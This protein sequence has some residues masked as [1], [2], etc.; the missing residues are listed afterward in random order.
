MN[1]YGISSPGPLATRSTA[2]SVNA[3]GITLT[4]NRPQNDFCRIGI[5]AL[6][7]FLLTTAPMMSGFA[8]PDTAP[9]CD[10]SHSTAT[11]SVSE[12][13]PSESDC[14]TM[15]TDTQAAAD[16]AQLPVADLEKVKAH[17]V[18]LRYFKAIGFLD[19]SKRERDA[20]F[21]IYEQHGLAVPEKFQQ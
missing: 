13:L 19:K 4:T 18:K 11:T 3:S 17:H 10:V 1:L 7:V 6:L 9:E 5:L 21:S 20:I 8:N 14:E 12:Q 15:T 16:A 2:T